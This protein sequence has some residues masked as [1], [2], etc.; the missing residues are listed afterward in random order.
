MWYIQVNSYVRDCPC[1]VLSSTLQEPSTNKK[2]WTIIV[3]NCRC[4]SAHIVIALYHPVTIGKVPFLRVG[5]MAIMIILCLQDVLCI[6]GNTYGTAPLK[7]SSIIPRNKTLDLC[8]T[9]SA[10]YWCI[11]NSSMHVHTKGT[12]LWR[13]HT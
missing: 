10:F 5:A 3:C 9:Y 6:H 11:N 4:N 1:K 7:Y 13:Q 8:I 12:T 2:T